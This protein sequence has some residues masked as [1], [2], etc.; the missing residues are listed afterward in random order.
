MKA[1]NQKEKLSYFFFIEK[2]EYEWKPE[3]KN[4]MK[5]WPNK[6]KVAAAADETTDCEQF[7]SDIA[8]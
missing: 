4:W 3:S 7:F 2:E 8:A 6:K 1:S 5:L